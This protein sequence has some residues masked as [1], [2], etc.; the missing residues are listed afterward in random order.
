[1]GVI[2]LFCFL[3]SKLSFKSANE[4]KI[5]HHFPV[6]VA[7][8]DY[9]DRSL[10]SNYHLHTEITTVASMTLL[11]VW[12]QTWNHYGDY[13]SSYYLRLHYHFLSC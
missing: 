11:L 12:K 4:I 13:A 9:N 7:A 3:S 6:Y 10:Q 5:R 8:E 2:T 1:M